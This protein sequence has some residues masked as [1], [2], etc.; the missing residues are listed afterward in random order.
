MSALGPRA[1]DEGVSAAW[2]DECKIWGRSKGSASMKHLSTPRVRLGCTVGALALLAASGCENNY[3]RMQPRVSSETTTTA[4]DVPRAQPIEKNPGPAVPPP[5][6]TKDL[7]PPSVM[8]TREWDARYPYPATELSR[9]ARRNR[10]AAAAL[11]AWEAKDSDKP[12]TLVEWVIAHPYEDVGSFLMNRP[13]WDEL[14][15]LRARYPRGVDELLEWA[16]HSPRAAEELMKRSTGFSSLRERA[17][18]R[19]L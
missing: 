12:R 7:P 5:I 15:S 9:W 14:S 17:A 6:V 18:V 4:V 16:R 8:S 2:R 1:E 3:A 13:G 10:D 11:A 19:M